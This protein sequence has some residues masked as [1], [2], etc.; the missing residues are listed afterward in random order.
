MTQQHRL[1]LA[2]IMLFLPLLLLGGVILKNERNIASAKKLGV[3]R[4][5]VMTRAICSTG[6]I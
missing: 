2:A 1:K 4:S 6:T 3:S 5:P